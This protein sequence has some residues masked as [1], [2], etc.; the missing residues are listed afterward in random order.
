ML[1]TKTGYKVIL[2]SQDAE[3]PGLIDLTREMYSF[4]KEWRNEGFWHAMT[5]EHFKEWFKHSAIDL[6]NGI[7]H[8][9]DLLLIVAMV[10]GLGTLAGSQKTGKWLYWTFITYIVVK[11]LGG[12][13]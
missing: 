7:V 12:A 11:L 4:S 10:L 5:G 6:F 3:K 2:T 13:L 1:A 9:S 8:Y